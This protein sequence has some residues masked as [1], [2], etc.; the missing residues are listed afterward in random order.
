MSQLTNW[1][2]KRQRNQRSNC[3]H[4]MGHRKNKGIPEK[5]LSLVHWLCYS[6][7]VDEMVGW[8]HW[9]NGYELRPMLGD[10]EGQGGLACYG[11]WGHK[12]T[13]QD[14]ESEQWQCMYWL[15]Q[16]FQEMC[17]Y[18]CFFL[19]YSIFK[20]FLKTIHFLLILLILYKNW[21]DFKKY[22]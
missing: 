18:G 8:L 14:L 4:L 15:T 10:G 13:G 1:I 2:L 3:Q 19:Y 20:I 7:C 16:I 22:L 5:H 11:L 21:I 12:R 17:I 6:L 9:T